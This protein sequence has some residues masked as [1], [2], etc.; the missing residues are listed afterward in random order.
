MAFFK[1]T[2]IDYS[3]FLPQNIAEA[4]VRGINT[5]AYGRWE[6]IRKSDPSLVQLIDPLLQGM[7]INLMV[8]GHVDETNGNWFLKN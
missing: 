4:L 2:D 3:A 5:F 8:F 7:W 1:R 6:E